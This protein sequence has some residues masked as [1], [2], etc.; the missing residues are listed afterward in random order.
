MT[1]FEALKTITDVDKW[2]EGVWHIARTKNTP[3]EF[4]ELLKSELTENELQI[5][6][7]AARDGNYPLS[8]EQL[9]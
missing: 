1:R 2:A 4:A 9:Q 8:L 3:E 5:L 7:C 6:R